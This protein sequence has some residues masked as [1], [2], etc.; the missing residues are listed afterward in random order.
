MYPASERSEK[1][2]DKGIRRVFTRP[3]ALT[4]RLRRA[5]GLQWI[6][7]NE[8]GERIPDDRHHALD[9]IVVAATT[10][11]LLQRATREVQEIE[12]KGLHY[13]L[14]KNVTP[15]WAHFR[16][17]TIEAV[18]KVFVARA[19]RRR[20]R[21]KAHD[22]TIR[23]IA[24]RDGERKVY[25]RKKVAD[26][27][28]ADLDR[29][30][31][32]DRNA[33]II[34]SLRAW[35]GAGKP[36]TAPPLSP[37]GDPISRVRLVTKGKVNI[38]MDTGNPDRLATVDRGEMARVDVFRKK[39]KKGVWEFYVVP[40]YP[41]Q[42]ATMDT[43]PMRSVTAHKPEGDW[44]VIDTSFEFLWSLNQMS[45]ISLTTKSGEISEGYFRELNR[46]DA[47]VTMSRHASKDDKSPKFGSKTLKDFK[48]LSV[49]RLG[50]ISEVQ[51]EL[52]TW[53]GK[54]CT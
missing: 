41:H 7:K 44:P 16:E 36:A 43:P 48:K 13:D 3:G 10:E 21:G 19:E 42:I 25:E 14:T 33:A 53:R 2:E 38:T 32:S 26:L 8:K 51:R 35:I 9:A 29:V 4:D 31:D 18:E 30:K 28:I 40:I 47:G 22:A 24:V 1:D 39:S 54:V 37:K 17:Q 20:T 52:R 5:W 50:G 46:D 23:H 49:D 6:K 11:S 45:Y 15:P 27:K 34:E 12:S